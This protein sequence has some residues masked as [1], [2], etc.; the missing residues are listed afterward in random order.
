LAQAPGVDTVNVVGY[1]NTPGADGFTVIAPMFVECGGTNAVLGK[2]TGDFEEWSDTLQILDDTLSTST[3]Y[4]WIDVT[5]DNNPPVWTSDGGTDDSDVVI[6]RGAAVVISSTEAVIQNRGQVETTAVSIDCSVGFSVLGNPTPVTIT[7]GDITFA[8]L[9]EWSDTLQILDDTLSTSDIYTWI[10][11]TYDN[12][13]PVWTSDGGTD[14][15]AVE[16]IPGAGFVLS[17]VNGATVTFPA[18]S[19]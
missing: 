16:L 1:V 10:D 12:N 19:L 14:D 8:G 6:P 7:L 4:T 5:Y 18:V 9:E 17:S 11:V 13:P 3:I 15:S 2:I